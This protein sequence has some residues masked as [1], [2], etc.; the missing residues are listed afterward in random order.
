MGR[1]L[2]PAGPVPFPAHWAVAFNVPE[3]PGY[4][5]WARP[6]NQKPWQESSFDLYSETRCAALDPAAGPGLALLP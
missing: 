3:S 1:A 6:A 4:P 2:V 5:P